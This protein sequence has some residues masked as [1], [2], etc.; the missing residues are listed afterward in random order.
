[1]APIALLTDFGHRDAYV[2]VM[3]G[4]IASLAP[5]VQV[6]DL[7][8]E[9]RP[10]AVAEAGFLLATSVP[11]FPNTT[12]FTAVV[13]PGVG[14]ARQILAARTSRGV[15]VAPDNGLL[16]EVLA[17]EEPSELVAVTNREL[18]LP[19]VSQTFHGRDV[20]APTAA[21]LA[22][23]RPLAELGPPL[24]DYLRLPSPQPSIGAD[25]AEG[26][27]RY[28][29][30]FGN[31][32]STIPAAGLPPV[33]SAQIGEATIPGPLRTSYVAVDLGEAL[34]IEGSSGFVEVSLNGG[35]AAGMLNLRVGAT[36]KLTF[37]TG[38]L[39]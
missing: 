2:G 5:E 24:E 27:I 13:D 38:G 30:H 19:R 39:A 35:D 10:Q 4:V 3:H 28:V 7:C 36:L 31:L 8:H 23:G 1:M 21:Q 26:V 34:L 17:D 25:S 18:F 20:F 11:F 6:I 33:A 32:V 15:F 9:V 14:S 16:T 12:V 37:R 22:L 29:D